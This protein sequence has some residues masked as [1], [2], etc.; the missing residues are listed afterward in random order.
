MTTGLEPGAPDC[1]WRVAYPS[2]KR[3]NARRWGTLSCGLVRI[4]KESRLGHPP[5]EQQTEEHGD[6]FDFPY[7]WKQ[8]YRWR[9]NL[10]RHTPWF[11]IDLGLFDKGQ[12]CESI[13][14]THEWYNIDNKTSGCYHCYVVREGRLWKEQAEPEISD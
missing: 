5:M 8:P 7:D 1:D 10:R 3:K 9:T 6:M 2:S 12:D 4:S 14:G 11:L 13:G